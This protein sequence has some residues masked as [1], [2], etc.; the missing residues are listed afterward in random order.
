METINKET[1]LSPAIHIYLAKSE[2]LM[3]GSGPK[4]GDNDTPGVNARFYDSNWEDD[5]EEEY[6]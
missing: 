6:E 3:A 4:A 2:P 5:I 1:Y